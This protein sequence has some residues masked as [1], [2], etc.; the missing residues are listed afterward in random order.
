[1]GGL[2]AKALVLYRRTAG[3]AW[4]AVKKVTTGTNGSYHATVKVSGTVRFKVAWLG[5]VRSA[6]LSVKEA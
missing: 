5:V 6:T 2:R 4:R 3:G 1:M